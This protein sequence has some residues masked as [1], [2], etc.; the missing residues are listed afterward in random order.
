MDWTHESKFVC[1]IN[2]WNA[3]FRIKEERR[4]VQDG[5]ERGFTTGKILACESDY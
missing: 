2:T 3:K 5:S 1:S 4:P